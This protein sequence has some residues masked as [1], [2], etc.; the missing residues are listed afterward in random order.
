M[1]LL[2]LLVVAYPFNARSQGQINKAAV[3]RQAN[4]SYY[5]VRASGLVEFQAR[6]TPNWEVAIKDIGA[7]PE[8]LRLL[9]GLK[10]SISFDSNNAIKMNHEV[11]IPAPNEQTEAGFNQIFAGMEQ[12]VSGFFDTWELFMLNSPFP[13]PDGS[14]DFRDSTGGYY[15]N[16]KEGN[17]DVSI[18]MNKDFTVTLVKVVSAEFE[19]SIWPKFTRSDKGFV[20]NRYS[21]K[22]LPAKGPGKVDLEIQIEHLD[23]QALKLPQRLRMHSVM[24]GQATETELTFSDYQVKKR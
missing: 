7:Q 20:L 23:V 12:M 8:T 19:S 1:A 3:I 24:D 10:F 4:S 2:M 18:E 13:P 5:S 11:G 22:Y 9:N 21:A 6:V 14:Y 17:A 16:Y 15:I